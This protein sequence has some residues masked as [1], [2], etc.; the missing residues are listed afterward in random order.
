M[1]ASA[2]LQS[3]TSPLVNSTSPKYVPGDAI[4]SIDAG[5]VVLVHQLERAR[6]A[7]LRPG[8]LAAAHDA[9]ARQRAAVDVGDHVLMDVDEGKAGHSAAFYSV[10]RGC[11]TAAIATRR[12]AATVVPGRG[13]GPTILARA[14][15]LGVACAA[16]A[17]AIDSVFPVRDSLHGNSRRALDN[18]KRRQAAGHQGGSITM[19]PRH[20]FPTTALLAAALLARP[21]SRPRRQRPPIS[22]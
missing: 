19:Q 6:H 3:R 17:M 15:W 13:H 18:Q 5:D 10:D 4:E 12:C 22:R 9:D 16:R 1:R 21:G 20:I 11:S 8:I 7:P 2:S 14:R